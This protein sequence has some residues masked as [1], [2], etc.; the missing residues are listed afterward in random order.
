MRICRRQL[1][2][3]QTYKLVIG[4][5]GLVVIVS[6]ISLFDSVTSIGSPGWLRRNRIPMEYKHGGNQNS[7]PRYTGVFSELGGSGERR[8]ITDSRSGAGKNENVLKWN[9]G[10]YRV[11]GKR[12]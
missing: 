5:A 3:W 6:V 10:E 1:E 11:E 4:F 8:Q 9:C 12:A 2:L 7:I